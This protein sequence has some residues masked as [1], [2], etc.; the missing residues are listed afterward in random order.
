MSLDTAKAGLLV[1]D[2]LRD[3]GLAQPQHPAQLLDRQVLA[4]DLADLVQGEAE[5]PKGEQAVEPA[6]G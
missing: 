2:I 1:S 5:V 4:E 6:A 3:L